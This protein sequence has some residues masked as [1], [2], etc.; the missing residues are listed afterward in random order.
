MNFVPN[1]NLSITAISVTKINA[2]SA[3]PIKLQTYESITVASGCKSPF[4]L[5]INQFAH[6][7]IT[8][9]T[10]IEIA[11]KKNKTKKSV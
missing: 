1:I 4:N 2:A 7:K 10:N 3:T 11:I 6:L 8:T 5:W 9:I